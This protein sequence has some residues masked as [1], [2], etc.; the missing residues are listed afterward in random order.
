M[1]EDNKEKWWLADL[2]NGRDWL[3]TVIKKD[4]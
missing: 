1:I 4:E 3:D 2:S